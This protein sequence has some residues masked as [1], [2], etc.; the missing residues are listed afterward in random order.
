MK[1]MKKMKEE[2]RQK[3]QNFMQDFEKQK[4]TPH[5]II[6]QIYKS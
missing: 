5:E 4:Q 2:K 3:I 1:V 6:D